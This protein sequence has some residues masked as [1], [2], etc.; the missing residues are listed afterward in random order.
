MQFCGSASG[1]GEDLREASGEGKRVHL[2][3][4]EQ[5]IR[6]FVADEICFI[7]REQGVD[8]ELGQRVMQPTAL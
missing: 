4:I 8:Q 1:V 6:V 7:Q 2:E 5:L 3:L